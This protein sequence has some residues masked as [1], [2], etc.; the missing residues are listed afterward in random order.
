[1]NARCLYIIMCIVSLLFLTD[2]KDEEAVRSS[3][4]KRTI[5]VDLGITMSRA[6][7]EKGV[8]GDNTR[9]DDLQLWIFDGNAA[10]ATRIFYDKIT[11]GLQFSFVDL[12]KK[13]VQTIERIINVENEINILHFYIVMNSEGIPLEETSTPQ[14]IEEATFTYQTTW[15]GDNKVPLYGY[16]TL[17]VSE[18][19]SEYSL[20]IDATRAVGK[21]EL[22]FTKENENSSLAITKV[23]ITQGMP[24]KGYL[25]AVPTDDNRTYT[26]PNPSV[27]LFESEDGTITQFLPE[28][29]G[30]FGEFSS[31]EDRF[32]SLLVSYL[33]ENPNGE[34]W[35]GENQDWTYPETPQGTSGCYK[36]VVSYQLN[37]RTEQG[38]MYLSEIKRNV[39]NKIF[40]RVNDKGELQIRYEAM[41][42]E[43]VTSEIG[44][45]P[46]PASTTNNPFDTEDEYKEFLNDGHYI[47]LPMDEFKNG[48]IDNVPE[49]YWDRTSVRKLFKLLYD[50]PADRGDDDARYC[51]LTK[52]TYDLND[53]SHRTLKTG[54]A[55]ARYFFMLTGP[56]GATWEAKLLNEDGTES[57]DFEFSYS[58]EEDFKGSE[59]EKDGKVNKVSHGIAREKPY[60]IQVNCVNAWTEGTSFSEKT[61]W[62]EL[63]EIDKRIV[64]T[65]LYITV[66]LA[67]G[68][69]Y[70]LDINSSYENSKLEFLYEYEGKYRRYAGE[71]D[72]VWIRQVPAQS[73][74]SYEQLANTD[75]SNQYWWKVNPYWK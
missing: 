75:D 57:K 48:E 16:N 23:E 56:T 72:F 24:D 59:Y 44:Y 15:T 1:M 45:A 54:T 26:A 33:L 36:V 50:Y 62:G 58:D 29:E 20:S 2:C 66:T 40:I 74:W 70:N 27:V 55:G 35:N 41:P 73:G 28:E 60:I 65:R 21:L 64:Q 46:K 13:L 53:G 39:W 69:T 32:R 43:V 51:I 25:A 37:E 71:D 34:K 9:P 52:P 22:F 14:E 6:T 38:E 47:L 17:D 11:D 4:G 10:D 12:N 5:T 61:E 18:H 7:D 67:D 30:A 3:E 63:N 8:I 31:H 68:V 42:W 19:R 49:S